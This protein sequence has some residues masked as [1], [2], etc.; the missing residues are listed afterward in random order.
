[1]VRAD[2]LYPT[3]TS[4]GCD[5]GTVL[6]GHMEDV[7]GNLAGCRRRYKEKVT[8][9]LHAD[10]YRLAAP[11]AVITPQHSFLLAGRS[12][13]PLRST[14]G[15]R[16]VEQC[17]GRLGQGLRCRGR[18]QCASREL[19]KDHHQYRRQRKRWCVI[20]Y[21]RSPSSGLLLTMCA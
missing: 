11:N 20:T 7:S 8:G 15:S 17:S 19:R 4:L 5:W 1:M 12:A 10:I 21:D 14:T 3:L 6:V 16:S 9:R 13:H 18:Q 2:E